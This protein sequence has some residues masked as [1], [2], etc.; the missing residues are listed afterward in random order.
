M[1]NSIE[2][3]I[4][5]LNPDNTISAHRHLA[6]AIGMTESIIYSALLSKQAYY[7]TKNMLLQEG[8]FYSTINDMEESTTFGEKAQKTAIKH[9]VEYGLIEC[10]VK[11]LPAKRHFRIVADVDKVKQLIEKG[12]SIVKKLSACTKSVV[13]GKS[14]TVRE[15][16]KRDNNQFLPSAETS[17]HH[18]AETC[19][20]PPQ[21][22]TKVIKP[23][24]NK[25]A[26]NQS[27]IRRNTPEAD[28]LTEHKRK[29]YKFADVLKCIGIDWQKLMPT[30]PD[31][32]KALSDYDEDLRM[33]REC[34]I[35]Y[36]IKE[37]KSAIKSALEYVSGYSY[38]QNDTMDTIRKEFFN[39]VISAITEMVHSDKNTLQG[40][41]VMYYEVI[42]RLNEIISE[43]YLG[44]WLFSF[45]DKWKEVLAN[46]DIKHPKA[47]IKGEVCCIFDES[48]NKYSVLSD[49]SRENV[50]E[51]LDTMGYGKLTAEILAERITENAD[52]KIK[53]NTAFEP[54]NFDSNN[55]ELS[56]MMFHNSEYGML[57]VQESGEQFKYMDIDKGTPMAEVEKAILKSFDI[58]DEKSAAEI[59]KQLS[60]DSIIET[61]EPKKIGDTVIQQ[62]STNYVEISK[63]EASAIMPKNKLD[64]EKLAEMG[65]SN[66]TVSDIQK[67]FK[68]AEKIKK[69]PDKQTLQQLKSFAE[70]AI[71]AGKDKIAEKVMSKTSQER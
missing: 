45:E 10:V 46:N 51:I 70:K 58:K 5:L 56:N 63:G 53:E 32:E 68:T 42:D 40:K 21:N 20:L 30:E 48:S 16:A 60:S 3:I 52:T 37:D 2:K 24:I 55:P 66:K 62:L 23:K 13:S 8:W 6:H 4:V 41:T 18:K 29:K 59:M 47:Y 64:K 44:S 33:T 28:R 36:Y 1:K 27:F 43:D 34:I 9:L 39:T 57:I 7:S 61:A 50:L 31:T 17:L 15:T 35:P 12:K 49:M 25:S 65:I 69:E 19:L 11:G 14:E 67:S 38:Y 22:K 26:F 71:K 54:K